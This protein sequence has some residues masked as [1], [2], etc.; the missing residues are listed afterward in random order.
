MNFNFRLH[1]VD[2][3]SEFDKIYNLIAKGEIR[4]LR[5]ILRDYNDTQAN[6]ILQS[7][8]YI[9]KL[10]VNSKAIQIA[11]D[12]ILSSF[13]LEKQDNSRLLLSQ[14]FYRYIYY[15]PID[16]VNKMNEK[17]L[18]LNKIKVFYI[19]N[20]FLLKES[21]KSFLKLLFA[22]YSIIFNSRKIFNTKYSNSNHAKIVYLHNVTPLMTEDFKGV[23]KLHNY[24]SYLKKHYISDIDQIFVDYKI[25]SKEND[26]FSKF[27]KYNYFYERKNLLFEFILFIKFIF[28]TGYEVFQSKNILQYSLQ[29]EDLYY[30]FR[31]INIKPD[32]TN[33][34]IIF[35]NSQG[36]HKPLCVS[37]AEEFGAHCRYIF[38]STAIQPEI[39]TGE[40]HLFNKLFNWNSIDYPSIPNSHTLIKNKYFP[41]SEVRMV[42]MPDISDQNISFF[43]NSI[44]M[45]AVFDIEP[46]KTFYGVS[47]YTELG[48]FDPAICIKF[49]E[50]IIQYCALHNLTA[51]HK[52][53]REI[54][55]EY[56]HDEYTNNIDR[57]VLKYPNNFLSV[58][59]SIS[60]RRIIQNSIGAISMPFTSTA[61]IASQLGIPTLFYDTT[62][63]LNNNNLALTGVRLVSQ[64][65][66]LEKWLAELSKF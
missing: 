50:E 54:S 29:L 5:E 30:S 58:S 62:G 24:I 44:R 27:H 39:V 35:N 33:A 61:I 60:A 38:Y 66:K 52:T 42:D 7:S 18:Y 23:I 19:N 10:G 21:A 65:N 47:G 45:V 48:Y 55:G 31:I 11:Y 51:V 8:S 6:K 49:L 15:L 2:L 59:S 16:I 9:T 57:L 28:F 17:N 26:I 25:S 64:P 43:S 40:F 56:K 22:F 14:N 37:I 4:K 53:K 1:K 46:K 3:Q 13:I 12:Q 34:L 36:V 41:I 63:K 32:L 20:I